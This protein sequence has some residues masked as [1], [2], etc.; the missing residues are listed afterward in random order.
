M[1]LKQL[2]GIENILLIFLNLIRAEVIIKHGLTA[3]TTATNTQH[4]PLCFY[5]YRT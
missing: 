2:N 3:L 4:G 1:P 5:V